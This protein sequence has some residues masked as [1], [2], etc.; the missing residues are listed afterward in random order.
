MV[1]LGCKHNQGDH[2]LYIKHFVTSKL[3]IL[4]VYVNGVIFLAD[5]ETNK[6]TLKEKFGYLI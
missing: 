5:D 3:T 1:S 6:L 4:L 2:I